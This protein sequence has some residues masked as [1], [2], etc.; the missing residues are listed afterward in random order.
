MKDLG[1]NSGIKCLS[2]TCVAP[3]SIPVQHKGGQGMTPLLSKAFTIE[4]RE[5]RALRCCFVVMT[6]PLQ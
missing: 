4:K 2:H 1:S 3:S 6:Q 5:R